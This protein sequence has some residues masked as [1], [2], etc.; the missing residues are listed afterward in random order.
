[1]PYYDVVVQN[2]KG[3]QYVITVF[4]GIGEAMAKVRARDAARR[5]SGD[6]SWRSVAITRSDVNPRGMLGRR[7]R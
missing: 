4:S 3:R 1:M 2:R 7:I 6:H 5:Q